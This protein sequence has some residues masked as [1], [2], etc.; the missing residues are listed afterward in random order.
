MTETCHGI[1]V[2]THPLFR[3]DVNVNDI[4]AMALLTD[5][6]RLVGVNLDAYLTPD[7]CADV[8][9][10]LRQ[11]PNARPGNINMQNVIAEAV[12]QELY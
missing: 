7:E 6:L 10:T 3:M 8:A 9:S 12:E 4:S 1:K 5:K 11:G 2:C